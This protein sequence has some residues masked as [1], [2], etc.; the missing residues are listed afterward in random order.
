MNWFQ[1]LYRRGRHH[2]KNNHQIRTKIYQCLLRILFQ[3][4]VSLKADIS[5]DVYFCHE[6][7]GT[8]VHP[9]SRIGSGTTVYHGVTIGQLS[10]NDEAPIIGCNVFIGANATI[11]GKI[12]IGDN[13]KIGACALVLCDVPEGCTAVGVPAKIIY[14]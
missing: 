1:K 11:L 9:M 6:G 8:G 5:D 3:S 13:A 12:K 7:F 14:K 4:D 10:G 2:Y